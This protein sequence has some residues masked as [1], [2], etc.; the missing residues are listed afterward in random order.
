MSGKKSLWIIVGERLHAYPTLM[1]AVQSIPSLEVFVENFM[2]KGH[3]IAEFSVIDKGG[4]TEF[5]VQQLDLKTVSA[6]LLE[7]WRDT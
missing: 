2:E 4:T 1:D 6:T 3:F 5:H 7:L